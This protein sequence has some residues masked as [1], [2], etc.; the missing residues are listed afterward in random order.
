MR[1]NSITNL[2]S[3]YWIP[4]PIENGEKEDRKWR[5]K[6]RDRFILSWKF[7]DWRACRDNK[8]TRTRMRWFAP[9]KLILRLTGDGII[10]FAFHL[11][12][13]HFCLPRRRLFPSRRTQLSFRLVASCFSILRHFSSPSHALPLST[14]S[15]SH[16]FSCTVALRNIQA[17][18]NYAIEFRY[19]RLS[20]TR[21][22]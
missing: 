11:S 4:V 10:V 6:L 3:W 8:C 1:N 15:F 17:A 22:T 2:A 5:K 18:V 7:R 13:L 14:P 12:C 21:Q 20:A 19:A 16:P 9:G